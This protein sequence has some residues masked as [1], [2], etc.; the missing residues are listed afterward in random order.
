MGGL[1]SEREVSLDSGKAVLKRS[2]ARAMM[3]LP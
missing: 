2:P 3:P 1:S